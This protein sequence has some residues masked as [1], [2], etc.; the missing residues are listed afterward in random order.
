MTTPLDDHV[1]LYRREVRKRR[2]AIAER[3]KEIMKDAKSAYKEA[4]K[5]YRPGRP[6]GIK[7]GKRATDL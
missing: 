5:P 4:N 1:K 2:P 7:V 3:E 6:R